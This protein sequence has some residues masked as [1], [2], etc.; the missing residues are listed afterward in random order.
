MTGAIGTLGP[1]SS[2]DLDLDICDT[3]YCSRSGGLSAFREAVSGAFM[4][5][6]IE[7]K[8]EVEFEARM[9]R[10][11]SDSGTL[12]RVRMTP[13][14][15]VRRNHEIAKSSVDCLYGNYVISGEI[16]VEQGGHTA[17]ARRGDIVLYDST[18]PVKL[19]EISDGSYEDL[20]I[21]I[22]MSKLARS[23]NVRSVL[24]NVVI[25]AEQMISPLSSCLM[26]LTEN[27]LTSSADELSAL[28]DTCA[29][30]LPVAAAHSGHRGEYS[31]ELGD[32][33]NYYMGELMRFIGSN[34]G[35]AALSPQ[36][37]AH[38][39]GIS[40][41]YVHKQFAGKGTTFGTYVMARRLDLVRH[42]LISE[43]CRHQPISAL[44]YRWGFNDLSTFIRA[45]K[46]RFG[47]SPRQYRIR[48]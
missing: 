31:D 34:I 27:L 6:T 26:F 45:F 8:S 15:A 32:R 42:D 21:R 38:H 3:E 28:Q 16:H 7:Y 23:K 40:V 4:P 37:A 24:D 44:A 30:L 43:A 10:V 29:A 18:L 35:D 11:A 46:K 39:L 2:S 12:A 5:W 41:R 48:V 22:P 33:P 36:C 47:C 14:V 1:L 19:T 17:I 13:L 25:T 9:V 20:A